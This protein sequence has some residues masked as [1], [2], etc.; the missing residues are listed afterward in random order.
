MAAHAYDRLACRV[1]ANVALVGARI[2]ITTAATAAAAA[3]AVAII[4]IVVVV[5]AR[6]RFVYRH[7]RYLPESIRLQDDSKENK[8]SKFVI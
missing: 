5:L 7:H 8:S 4:C 2:A 3:A 1:Q 6:V